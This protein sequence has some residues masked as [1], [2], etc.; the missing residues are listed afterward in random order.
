M[1]S[2]QDYQVGRDCHRIIALQVNLILLVVNRCAEINV[3]GNLVD[4]N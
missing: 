4:L 1:C 2:N 3:G